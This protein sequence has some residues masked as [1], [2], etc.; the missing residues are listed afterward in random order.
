MNSQGRCRLI[1][2]ILKEAGIDMLPMKFMEPE[3][4]F[5]SVLIKQRQTVI[6]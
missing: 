5:Y 3:E 1:H 2:K 4:Q 6:L